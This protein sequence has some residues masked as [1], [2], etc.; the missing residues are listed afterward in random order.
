MP[1]AQGPGVHRIPRHS[2]APWKV[3]SGPR[4]KA[5]ETRV[6]RRPP[7]VHSP[8]AP[9][10][11][12]CI[13]L[14]LAIITTFPIFLLLNP[15]TLLRAITVMFLYTNNENPKGKL[16]KDKIHTQLDEGPETP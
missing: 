15:E 10:L 8:T 13:L 3:P 5:R 7:P 4:Q 16:R 14:A 12:L 11:S 9:Q 2:E 6:S 1:K